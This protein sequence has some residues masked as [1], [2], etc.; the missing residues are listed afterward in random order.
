[1][2]ALQ[3]LYEEFYRAVR[4]DPA[5]GKIRCGR[6]C[7]RCCSQMV[8]GVRALEVEVLGQHL[9][10]TGQVDRVRVAL[11]R[12]LAVYD[13]IKLET[14][15]QPGE[16]RDDWEERVALRFFACDRP[17]VFLEEDGACGVHALRP[18]ACRRFFSLSD[19]EFCDAAGVT[20]SD[21]RGVMVEPHEALDRWSAVLDYAAP[22]DPDT[23]LLDRALLRWIEHRS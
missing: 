10:H 16:T 2:G 20:S 13:E 22:F 9:R 7:S 1:M 12:R 3:G 19:P 15:R 14:S 5:N 23:D 11:Q 18:Y 4:E 8:F 17:C 21:H 6:G